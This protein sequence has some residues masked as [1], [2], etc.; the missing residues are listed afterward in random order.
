LDNAT[1]GFLSGFS[2]NVGV[3]LL[4]YLS[5]HTGLTKSTLGDVTLA[6]KKKNIPQQAQKNIR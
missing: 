3:V 2:K 1:T 4:V 6:F 5:A